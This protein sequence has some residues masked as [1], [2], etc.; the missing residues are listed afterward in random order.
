MATGG[1]DRVCEKAY[2]RKKVTYPFAKHEIL[3]EVDLI[4]QDAMDEVVRFLQRDLKVPPELRT[5]SQ[6]A[7]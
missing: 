3:N 6:V 7:Q 5:D 4:R 1:Q 2:Y